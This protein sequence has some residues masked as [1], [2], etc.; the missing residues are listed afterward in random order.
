V[1]STI[2]TTNALIVTLI[3]DAGLLEKSCTGVPCDDLDDC[4]TPS[5][6]CGTGRTYCNYQATWSTQGCCVQAEDL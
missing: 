5:G 3:S 6:E 4:R 2:G 1:G